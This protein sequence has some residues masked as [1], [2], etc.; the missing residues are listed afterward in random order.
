[1]SLPPIG[2]SSANVSPRADTT[3]RKKANFEVDAAERRVQAFGNVFSMMESKARELT[4]NAHSRAG[5][6]ATEAEIRRTEEENKQADVRLARGVL[7]SLGSKRPTTVDGFKKSR[8]GTPRAEE[9]SQTPASVQEALRATARDCVRREELQRFQVLAAREADLAFRM[10]KQQEMMHAEHELKLHF[11]RQQEQE[12]I[13][14]KAQLDAKRAAAFTSNAE[15]NQALREEMDRTRQQQMDKLAKLIKERRDVKEKRNAKQKDDKEK[16]E[17][18]RLAMFER[19]TKARQAEQAAAAQDAARETQRRLE[20][21]AKEAHEVV[22]RA[23]SALKRFLQRRELAASRGHKADSSVA[24]DKEQKR[25]EKALEQ[26]RKV[27]ETTQR[28]FDSFDV[29]TGAYAK[30]LPEE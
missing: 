25:L 19:R 26:A 5:R 14:L 24:F 2:K 1:M 30:K 6:L 21:V 16:E 8:R 12:T 15:E 9:F 13:K 20:M 28:N 10:A 23:D 17:K 3:P 27:A 22:D 4:D 18:E 11:K 29:S 7:G